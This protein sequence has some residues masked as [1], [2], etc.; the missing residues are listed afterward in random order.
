M[1]EW[2]LRKETAGDR[3]GERYQQ[4]GSAGSL[5]P[6]EVAGG[7]SLRPHPWAAASLGMSTG[8]E[9]GQN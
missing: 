7:R 1:Q 3:A 5:G 8:R 9:Q 6:R 4:G 2:G